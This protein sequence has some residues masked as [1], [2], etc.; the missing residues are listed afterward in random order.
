[1]PY[2][3][4]AININVDHLIG[5]L[6]AAAFLQ[7]NFG[8]VWL[9]DQHCVGRPFIYTIIAPNLAIALAWCLGVKRLPDWELFWRCLFVFVTIAVFGFTV[10]NG[11][12]C[13]A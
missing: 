13:R 12:V 5:L 4:R 8:R 7:A 1:M 6:C 9:Q 11:F 2:N 3:V 10:W